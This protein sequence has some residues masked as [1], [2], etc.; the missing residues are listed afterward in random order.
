M[1][2][3]KDPHA[4]AETTRD[5]DGVESDRVGKW[6]L[7]MAY[8]AMFSAMFW[9]YIAV[10]SQ[11]AVGTLNTIIGMVLSI[12]SYGAIN[13]VL[14]R[15]AI[16][17][18]HTISSF[19]RA[20]FGPLGSA[21]AAL[22]FAVTAIYYATFEGSIIAVALR[23]Y[24][25][26][27]MWLWYLAVVL[28]ALPLVAHGVQN[29]LDKLNGVLLPL[30]VAGLIAIVV[31][32]TIKQGYPSGWMTHT[33]AQS[34]AL[35]GW[36]S[37]YL[38]Y[39]GV[40]VMMMYTYE[41]ARLGRSQHQRF[42]GTVT[43]GWVFYL[44]TFGVNGLVGIYLVTAWKVEGTETGV[45]TAILSSLGVVG[46]I[47]IVISQTRINTANYYA[48]STNLQDL[49]ESISGR[50]TPRIVWVLVAGVFA[51]LFMLTDVLS[52]LLRALAWQGVFVTA[53]VA[54]ALTAIY[55][56]SHARPTATNPAT[57][58]EGYGFLS[59]W[60]IL[61]WIAA[62]AIGIALT[63]QTMQPTLAALSPAITVVIA[64]VLYAAGRVRG[65]QKQRIR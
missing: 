10:A 25:G 6:S 4:I 9:L 47:V 3:S 36:L 26:G 7:T 57:A 37:S 44:L 31:G 18:G 48:A 61:S 17:Y 15:H 16:R 29:W 22:L 8:W 42:H 32:A 41:F 35:P 14:S 21:L 28:Y 62:S 55:F 33:V 56:N 5:P 51:Y 1:F 65:S 2:A 20:I 50:R 59:A 46:L 23:E 63:E 11:A 40:W 24:F 64:V 34:S 45:V 49:A 12:A 39:M 30:Y 13:A 43:F 58:S 60:P 54:I 19:S 52:Y 27:S 38:I 53:W